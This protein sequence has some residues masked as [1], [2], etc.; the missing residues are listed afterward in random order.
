MA[1]KKSA[2]WGFILHFGHVETSQVCPLIIHHTGNGFGTIQEGME[3][4]VHYLFEDYV[5]RSQGYAIRLEEFQ[6]WLADICN[7]TANEWDHVHV[8]A[9]EWWPWDDL[10]ELYKDLDKFWEC[11]ESPLEVILPHYLNPEKLGNNPKLIKFRQELIQFHTPPEDEFQR[12]LWT[13]NRDP[14]IFKRVG[15]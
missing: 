13:K 4:L 15:K 6:N 14:K 5:H 7:Y 10:H 11:T 1:K 2:V 12:E 8:N 9:E 3:H